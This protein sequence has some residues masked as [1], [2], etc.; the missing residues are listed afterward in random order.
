MLGNVWEWVE[1]CW[2]DNYTGAPLDGRAWIAGGDCARRVLRGGSWSAQPRQV[3][4][5][6]RI[7]NT[8]LTRLWN[9]NGYRSDS[10][11]G[12]RVARDLAR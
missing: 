6:A 11:F 12:F 2:H 7:H 9:P 3:R 8:P 4:A 10:G 1:D 5:A